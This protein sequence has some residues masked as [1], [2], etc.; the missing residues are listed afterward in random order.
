MKV[1]KINIILFI[2]PVIFGCQYNGKKNS[3]EKR[4]MDQI[5]AL[6][7]GIHFLKEKCNMKELPSEDKVID[8]A[9]N[10]MGQGEIATQSNFYTEISNET[11]VRYEEIKVYKAE[12]K[13][14]CDELKNLLKHF[15]AKMNA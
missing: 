8:A 5:T 9:I 11:K 15:M 2:T 7:S 12:Q 1:K 13:I 14:K 3:I 10:M 4:K 6:T